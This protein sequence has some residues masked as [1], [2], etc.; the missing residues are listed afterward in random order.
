MGSSHDQSISILDNHD[1]HRDEIHVGDKLAGFADYVRDAARITLVH[2][3]VDPAF[4]GHGIGGK[5]AAGAL[6]DVRAQGLSVVPE[7]SFVA[8]YIERHPDYGDL[9]APSS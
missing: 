3:A 9:V 6:G 4:E 5:L 8:S 2:T 7:C 1:E